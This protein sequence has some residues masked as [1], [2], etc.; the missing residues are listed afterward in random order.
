MRASLK[1][2]LQYGLLGPLQPGDTRSAVEQYLGASGNWHATTKQPHDS[3]IWKYGNIEFYFNGDTL[4][5]IFMDDFT[6]PDGTP[7]IQLAP[8]IINSQLTLYEAEQKLA[9]EEIDYRKEPFPYAENGIRLIT[10]PG[11][12]MTFSSEDTANP[13]LRALHRQI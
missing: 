10:T 7:T 9:L 3:D 6:T 5:M 11:T 1:E 4:W 13:T 8:W 2:F 12:I